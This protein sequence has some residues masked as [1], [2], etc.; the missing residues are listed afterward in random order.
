ML[1]FRY[2]FAYNCRCHVW[3]GL[4]RSM[5]LFLKFWSPAFLVSKWMNLNLFLPL[6]WR[7]LLKIS[8]IHDKK[9][10]VLY[11]IQVL[12]YRE[13]VIIGN[14]GAEN[15]IIIDRFLTYLQFKKSEILRPFFTDRVHLPQGCGAASKKQLTFNQQV[16]RISLYSVTVGWKTESIM[17]PTSRSW[18]P[19]KNLLKFLF[20]HFFVVH[21]KV[22]LRS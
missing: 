12:Y 21:Q 22:L 19:V 14:I 20:S 15:T 5:L 11:L 2:I 3:Q 10:V 8:R 6:I 13:V 18:N 7:R 4:S 9:A 17:E 1:V 16:R